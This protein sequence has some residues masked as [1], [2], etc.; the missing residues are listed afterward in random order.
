M[1]RSTNDQTPR[2]KRI[3]ALWISVSAPFIGMG[4]VCGCGT[5]MDNRQP[6]PVKQVLQVADLSC[7]AVTAAV[8]SPVWVPQVI[9]SD[10]PQ[11]LY[12]M[13]FL[14]PVPYALYKAKLERRG[15]LPGQ[16]AESKAAA[17]KPQE[18]RLPVPYRR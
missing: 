12:G 17:Q 7:S 6:P 13:S 16:S 2:R 8:W 4:F 3:I 9:G 14:G 15:K 5:L 18:R 11:K 1:I 10:D